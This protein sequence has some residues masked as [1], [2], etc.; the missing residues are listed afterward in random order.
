MEKVQLESLYILQGKE[1]TMMS[2]PFSVGKEKQV[3]YPLHVY[4][5]IF[6]YYY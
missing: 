6:W 3:L 4:L 5:L 1:D 2:I